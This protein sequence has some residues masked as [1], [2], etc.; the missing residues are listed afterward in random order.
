MENPMNARK[1]KLFAATLLAGMTFG[2]VA[3]LAQPS[4]YDPAQLPETKGKV[5]QYLLNPMGMVDGLLMADGTEIRLP[6]SASTELV[7]AV[8]PGDA[9]TVHGLKARALPLVAAASVTNDATGITVQTAPGIR[10][11]HG[12]PGDAHGGMEGHWAKHPM[13]G[14]MGMGGH[15]ALDL[16][17]KVKASLHNARGEANGVVLEDGSQVLLPPPEA[18]RLADTLAIGKALTVKGLGSTSLLGKVVIARQIGPDAAHLADV[19]GPRGVMGEHKG[20]MDAHHGMVPA[21]PPTVTP[22]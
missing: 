11:P 3:A 4:P 22:Q 18:K 9:I 14:P 21:H 17:G 10:A 8:R 6:P 2:L 20:M 16:T 1:S 15:E 12:T 13:G 7:F 19:H 5:A